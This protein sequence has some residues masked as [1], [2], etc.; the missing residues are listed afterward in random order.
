MAIYYW[1]SMIIIVYKALFG[2]K[3]RKFLSFARRQVPKSIF[4]VVSPTP[5][6][7]KPKIVA[8]SSEVLRFSCRLNSFRC[9]YFTLSLTHRLMFPSGCDITGS[10]NT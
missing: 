3:Y 9:V 4:S 8:F 2:F 10:E 5:W 6:K 1:I 7:T